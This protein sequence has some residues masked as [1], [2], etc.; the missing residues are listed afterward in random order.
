MSKTATSLCALAACAALAAIPVAH[1]QAPAP[2]YNIP[3]PPAMAAP[4]PAMSYT[5]VPAEP[6][7]PQAGVTVLPPSAL[8]AVPMG[9]EGNAAAIAANNRESAWYDHL[10]ETNPS[11]RHYRMRKECGPITDP[12]LHA[13]CIASFQQYEPTMY[14]SSFPPARYGIGAGE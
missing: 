12:Q 14:G 3:P 6:A 5:P 13:G 7:A 11:F 8:P 1:A 9:D 10:V 4:P 2:T